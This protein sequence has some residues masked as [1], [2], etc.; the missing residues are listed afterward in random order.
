[1]GKDYYKVLGVSRTATDD[2]LKKAYRK[3]ALKYHP[4]KNCDPGAEEK[5]KEIAE[6][7]SDCKCWLLLA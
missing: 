7:L 4:D 1:M 3:M 6:V 5:F 2:E